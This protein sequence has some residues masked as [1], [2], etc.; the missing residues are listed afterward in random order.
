MKP[1]SA[2]N[3]VLWRRT[4][5]LSDVSVDPLDG[6]DVIL[7]EAPKLIHEFAQ[8]PLRATVEGLFARQPN[9]HSTWFCHNEYVGVK[10]R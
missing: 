2:T 8:V 6:L 4:I 3:Q 10:C 9:Q 7:R 5:F 1:L